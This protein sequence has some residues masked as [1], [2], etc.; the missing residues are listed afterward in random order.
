MPSHVNA[1]AERRCAT[2]TSNSWSA[3]VP[4]PAPGMNLTVYWF[5]LHSAYSVT[6]SAPSVSMSAPTAPSS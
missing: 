3:I 5:A 2:P 4:V 1:F 6:V